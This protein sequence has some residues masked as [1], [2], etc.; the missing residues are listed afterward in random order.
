MYSQYNTNSNGKYFKLRAD[1]K[2]E[3]VVIAYPKYPLQM[4]DDIC[5]RLFSDIFLVLV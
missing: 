4:S 3:F 5:W 1:S 2:C